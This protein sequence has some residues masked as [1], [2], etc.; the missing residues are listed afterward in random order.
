MEKR[1]V[2]EGAEGG[3]KSRCGPWGRWRLAEG[4]A[5]QKRG[6]ENG[7]RRP[8]VRP[9]SRCEPA[10]VQRRPAEG[11]P[12]LRGTI[13]RLLS[14]QH[15]QPRGR[16]RRCGDTGTP[17]PSH[18]DG[19]NSCL[20]RWV[21]PAQAAVRGREEVRRHCHTPP[22]PPERP[23]SSSFS[24]AYA[25]RAAV[26][27]H[28]AAYAGAVRAASRRRGRPKVTAPPNASVSPSQCWGG[29]TARAG[30][31][32]RHGG[33]L[34]GN[35]ARAHHN[36]GCSRRA[37]NAQCG[38]MRDGAKALTN[39]TP[40][41]ARCV[42]RLVQMSINL[43]PSST[44]RRPPESPRAPKEKHMASTPCLRSLAPRKNTVVEMAEN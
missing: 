9:P 2:G 20:S 23:Q 11:R 14:Y 35:G 38:T 27:R 17:P 13:P 26:Q 18:P 5:E 6:G 39:A 8:L 41:S 32:G 3:K 19:F 12:R 7:R 21:L 29:A 43:K 28:V 30:Q 16:D 44:D 33:R 1:E 37:A 25:P 24:Q 34:N 15:T 40:T 22:A 42:A 36:C 10:S 4:M 31:A